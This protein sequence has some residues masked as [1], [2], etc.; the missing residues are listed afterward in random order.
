MNV[1]KKREKI[2]FSFL[3]KENKVFLMVVYSHLNIILK[4]QLVRERFCCLLNVK[5]MVV[6]VVPALRMND[7][8][9]GSAREDIVLEFGF[10]SSSQVSIFATKFLYNIAMHE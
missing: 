4:M 10:A 9:H 8:S 3:K 7:V 1:E 2:Y 5:V 6:L